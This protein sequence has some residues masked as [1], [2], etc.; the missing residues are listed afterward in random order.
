MDFNGSYLRNSVILLSIGYEKVVEF[1]VGFFR[2]WTVYDPSLI[3]LSRDTQPVSYSVEAPGIGYYESG[4]ILAN[5][6]VIVSFPWKIMVSS[7]NHQNKGILLKTSSDK[8]T[9]TGQSAKGSLSSRSAAWSLDTFSVN[10]VMDLS[11]NEYEYFAASVNV[12][13]NYGCYNSS[14][15]IVGTSNDTALKLMVTQLVTTMVGYSIVTLIPGREYSFVI[16]RLQTVYLSSANDLTGT[17]IVTNN[18]VSVFS[19]HGIGSII[20]Y[21]GYSSYLMEQMPPTV[22]WGNKHYITSLSNQHSK[23]AI[24]LLAANEC[25]LN[26]YCSSHTNLNIP[27]KSKIGVIK[28][29]LNNESCEI[30]S[31]SKVLVVQF[32]VG[33]R[34]SGSIMTLVP[35]TK[36]YLNKMAFSAYFSGYDYD[37]NWPETHFINIIVLAQYYQPDMIYLITKGINRTLATQEWTPIKV[38]NITKA[39]ATSLNISLGMGQIIH[40]NNA[41]LMSAMVYGFARYGGYGTTANAF[42]FISGRGLFS[43]L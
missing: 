27:L 8:V 9:V 21:G 2:G 38:N 7:Y 4:N 14:V 39:Y 26:I 42:N 13:R 32:S 30:Q 17:R 22:L 40:N 33:F 37:Y 24:K 6:R 12:S 23:Y 43:F 10:E 25:M 16:N 1:Y 3:I 11:I 31:S 36:H 34:Y 35:P 28:I 29:L 15:L 41:A 19:G 18:P 20:Y 5:D